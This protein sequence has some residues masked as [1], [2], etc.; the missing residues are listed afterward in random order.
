MAFKCSCFVLLYPLRFQLG[1]GYC[2]CQWSQE[3][4]ELNELP[5][6]ISDA[7]IPPKHVI[8]TGRRI[9]RDVLMHQIKSHSPICESVGDTSKHRRSQ[10]EGII[11]LP[12]VRA[13]FLT[14]VPASLTPK[15]P[16]GHTNYL[17]F[18][19]IIL[20]RALSQSSSTLPDKVKY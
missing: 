19:I 16:G 13:Q 18:V 9:F 5:N 10:L 7:L 6:S 3:K 8:N 12:D 17:S 15:N 1:Y 14:P 4:T 11:N 20:H 2:L